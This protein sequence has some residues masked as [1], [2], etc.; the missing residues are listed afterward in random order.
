[1]RQKISTFIHFWLLAARCCIFALAFFALLGLSQVWPSEW[2]PRYD[3]IFIGA[4]LIQFILWKSKFETGEEVLGLCLFHLAGFALEIF[5]VHPSIASWSYPE[6]GYSKFWGVPL[7]S[8][9][10][11]AAVASSM[12]QARRVFK[13]RLTHAP[14]KWICLITGVTLFTNFFTHHLT[15]DWRWVLLFA[16]T[17]LFYRAQI[18]ISF[19]SITITK[20]LPLFFLF[21]GILVWIAEN[22]STLLGAWKYP[23][24]IH[25]WTMVS[26]SK[27]VSWTI[28]AIF[29]FVLTHS[30]I[31]EKK[32]FE[33]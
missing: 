14:P 31:R 32:I 18:T 19:R 15:Y 33:S 6:V 17:I 25:T 24:Q 23:D 26:C 7:Y 9:F 10:M 21:F 1:M 28:L 12:Y 29:C 27:I 16:S 22:I 5:K 4:L 30:L 11:Y 3:F 2:L 13:L 20:A 8:G